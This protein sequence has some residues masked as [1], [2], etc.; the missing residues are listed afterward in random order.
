[1]ILTPT[2]GTRG[3]VA[4]DDYVGHGLEVGGKQLDFYFQSIMT[5]L[6][7]IASRCPVLNVPSG[8]GDNGVPTGLQIVG[9]TYDDVTAFRVGAA[10]ER[11]RPWF[12]AAERRPSA[13]TD[14]LDVDGLSVRLP[15]SGEMRTVLDGVSFSIAPGEA[16]GLVGESGS[17]KSMTVRSIARLLPT[18]AEVDGT[19]TLRRPRR[20]Q[21]ARRPAALATGTRSRWSSRIRAHIPTRCGG[22][23]TS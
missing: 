17:G 18:G 13:M 16:L 10:L 20:L 3:L 14:L 9:R 21:P 4:G 22:S 1:M 2:V 23:A 19:V 6:F 11:E 7:N 5:P 8:F 12:D 15:V